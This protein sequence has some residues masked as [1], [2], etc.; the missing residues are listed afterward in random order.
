[1]L[2]PNPELEVMEFLVNLSWISRLNAESF[3]TCDAAG[4][5]AL[6]RHLKGRV[7]LLGDATYGVGRDVYSVPG[8]DQPVPGVLI[9]ACGAATALGK[10]LYELSH[11]A[12]VLVDVIFAVAII[13]GA[14]LLR[15]IFERDGRPVNEPFLRW[16]LTLG[17]VAVT[18]GGFFF[19]GTTHLLWTD[20]VLVA[21]ALLLHSRAE[22]FTARCGSAIHAWWDKQIHRPEPSTP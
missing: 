19:V 22:R 14:V 11:G 15:P 7:V 16:V 4:I 8:Y 13:G 3:S 10:P 2:K 5:R 6:Q 17:F 20:F 12:R 9:H 1:M 21:L 18:V